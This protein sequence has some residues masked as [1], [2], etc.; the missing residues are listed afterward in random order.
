M[1]LN[2]FFNKW[3]AWGSSRV[4]EFQSSLNQLD[5]REQYKLVSV[6]KPKTRYNIEGSLKD[7]VSHRIPILIALWETFNIISTL[8]ILH[9][10]FGM[11]DWSYFIF[12][13]PSYKIYLD[14]SAISVEYFFLLSLRHIIIWI[15]NEISARLSPLW[16]YMVLQ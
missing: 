15:A 12:G 11:L 1:L 9:N 3:H 5:E 4:P 13:I 7:R 14:E 2:R 10:M 6:A 8:S 16:T